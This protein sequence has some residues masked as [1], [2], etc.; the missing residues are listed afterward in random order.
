[1]K[2]PARNRNYYLIGFLNNGETEVINDTLKMTLKQAFVKV[3]QSGYGVD[4][5]GAYVIE[6]EA[7][8]LVFQIPEARYICRVFLASASPPE[9]VYDE[10]DLM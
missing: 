9:D 2:K 1:M 8:V 10:H 7:N 5:W 3:S 6:N 4:G